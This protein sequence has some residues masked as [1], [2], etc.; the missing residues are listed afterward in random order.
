MI[1]GVI[2]AA[3]ATHDCGKTTAI[4]SIWFYLKKNHASVVSEE[5][6]SQGPNKPEDVRAVLE[7]RGVRIGISSMGDPGIDQTGILDE[8]AKDGCRIV[9]CACRIWGGTKD[10][11]DALA[12]NWDIRYI[13]P[14][15]YGFISADAIWRE[16][17]TAIRLIKLVDRN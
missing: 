2:I 3:R 6:N 12:S 13:H 16:L 10:P 7:Y 15:D 11:I 4:R 5:F 8:F 9:I 17:M 1:Q 14:A